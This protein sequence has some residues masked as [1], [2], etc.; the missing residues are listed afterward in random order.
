MIA[1]MIERMKAEIKYFV[2]EPIKTDATWSKTK[3]NE[4]VA[5]TNHPDIQVV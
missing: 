4:A 2:I 1:Q 5:Q 3:A